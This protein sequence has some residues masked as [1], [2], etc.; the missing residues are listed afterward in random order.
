MAVVV[1]IGAALLASSAPAGSGGPPA[2]TPAPDAGGARPDGGAKVT[3]PQGWNEIE[4]LIGEQKFEAAAGAVDAIRLAAEKRGD[5]EE[6]TRALVKETQLR[7]GLH[8]FETAVRFLKDSAWPKGALHAAVLDL[9]YAHSLVTYLQGY[10][11][12]IGQREKVETNGAVDLKA[13]TREE[14]FTAAQRAYLDAW[15]RRAQL[16]TEPESR[17]SEYIQANTFPAGVRGTLRDAI[18]YLFVELLADTSNWRPDQSNEIYALDLAALLKSGASAAS[19]VK[20]DDPAVHPLVKLCAILDDLESWHADRGE[21]AA[22][23]EARLER[24]RRLDASFTEAD[25]RRAIRADLAQRLTGFR[26]VSW[27]AEGMAQLAELTREDDAPDALVRARASA[28]QGLDAYPDSPG[29]RHCLAIVKEIEAPD[30]GIEA[31]ASDAPGK[32][33]IEVTHAN[34]P[35]LYFRAFRMDLVERIETAQNYNLLPRSDE[36]KAFVR[37]NRPV[38]TWRTELPPTPDFRRHRTFVTP[39]LPGRGFYLIVSS[40]RE[41]FAAADNRLQSVAMLI[42]DMVLVSRADDGALAARV[43]S[44]TSGVPL[45]GARVD[46]YQYDWQHGHHVVDSA[47]TGD[48]GLVRFVAANERASSFFLLARRGDDLALDPQYQSFYKAPQPT[49]STAALVY[50]DRSIY[51]PHA[52]RCSGRSSPTAAGRTRRALHTADRQPGHGVAGRR[53]RPGGRLAHRHHERL[54][55]GVGRVRHP[56]RTP[57]RPLAPRHL[58]GR[59]QRRCASRSTSA[60]PSR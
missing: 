22:A 60:P 28:K 46:L 2:S 11:W 21:A 6:W 1:V 36:V 25:D 16:G 8:G 17:L 53:E 51:R 5:E 37:S 19:A 44:G 58:A 49:E 39:T 4:R 35:A 59:R 18:S 52:E 27:W 12:E 41:D 30:Y 43:L 33:S 45:S 7:I 56:G 9:F 31:M 57:A 34:L 42:G 20:L 38:A 29:G 13:W 47:T 26:S 50:T 55:L 40:A 3:Q 32:R 24:V 23:L 15:D 48:D 10:S 54:R 14:I